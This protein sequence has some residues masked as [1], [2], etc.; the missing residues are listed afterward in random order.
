[1]TSPIAAQSVS[2]LVSGRVDSGIPGR[3]LQEYSRGKPSKTHERV[4]PVGPSIT[5]KSLSDLFLGFDHTVNVNA[6]SAE[7]NR[8]EEETEERE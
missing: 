4:L 1:L 6:T 7:V 8:D 2:T 3:L 5:A